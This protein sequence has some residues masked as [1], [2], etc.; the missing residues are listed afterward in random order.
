MLRPDNRQ[1]FL[2]E[3]GNNFVVLSV[4]GISESK[5]KTESKYTL[6]RTMI[7][8]FLLIGFA[9]LLVGIEFILET[10]ELI[11][12]QRANFQQQTNR[13]IDVED[14]IAPI[15]RLMKKGML[16]IAIIMCVMVI[17]LM[18]F[19]KNITGPLQHMIE[20]SKEF[21]KGD[22]SHTI[23]IHS[24]NELAELGN[25]IN[26]MSSNLQEIIMF[27]KNLCNSG[28]GFVDRTS[29]ILDANEI[30]EEDM[31]KVVAEVV[32]LKNEL[33]TLGQVIEYFSFYTV[34]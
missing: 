33:E 8:Y 17:V 5:M 30:S 32:H 31:K 29:F 22:L 14:V 1:I 9:S 7:I 23:K 26:E 15:E 34:D 13:G 24:D 6:Q 20:M 16:M 21:S 19:I 28:M 4:T 25:V 10:H 11:N 3:L 18:M 2:W 27:S 12:T